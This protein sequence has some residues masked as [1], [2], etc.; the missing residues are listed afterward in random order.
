MLR[1]FLLLLGL[2]IAL[3]AAGC[4]E[5]GT[6]EK[7]ASQLDEA[8]R[9][10]AQKDQQ[11]RVLQWQLAVLD[12]Q[13]RAAAQHNEAVQQG[14]SAEMQKLAAANVELTERLNKAERD[15]AALEAAA[16]T[17]PP[18]GKDAKGVHYGDMRPEEMRRL[19]LTLDARNAQMVEEL[20]R[21]ERLLGKRDPPLREPP[22]RASNNDVIDP[23]GFGSR[24]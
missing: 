8:R 17:L 18:A 21:I 19:L 7:T 15:R 5:M 1:T 13:F 22:A 16:S 24:K 6:Y 10:G 23:W 12:Q 2:P 11:I 9:A 20:A 4:V 14:V 3:S